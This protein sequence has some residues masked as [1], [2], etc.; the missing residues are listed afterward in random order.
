MENGK[1]REGEYVVYRCPDGSILLDWE[2]NC[3]KYGY[4]YYPKHRC[5]ELER[6]RCE[7][8]PNLPKV[9]AKMREKYEGE[10]VDGIL[11]K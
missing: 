4:P 6:G 11:Q 2:E 3:W 5:T 9:Y 8:G 7:G 1:Y 10:K